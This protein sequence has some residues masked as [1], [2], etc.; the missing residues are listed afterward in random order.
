MTDQRREIRITVKEP[1]PGWW[2]TIKDMAVR[3]GRF[4]SHLV[5]EAI[6]QYVQLQTPTTPRPRLPYNLKPDNGQVHHDES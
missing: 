4:V 2:N 6:Q 1:T 3:Q 5:V